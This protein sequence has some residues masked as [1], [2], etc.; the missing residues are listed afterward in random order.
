DQRDGVRI[1]DGPKRVRTYLGGELIADTTRPKLVWEVPYYPA[2][3]FPREDVRTELLTPNGQTRH[4]TS[5]GE[6]QNFRVKG[7]H[8]EAEDLAWSYQTPRQENVK[9]AGLVAFFNEKV[10]L[11][12]DGERQER[13]KTHFS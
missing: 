1:E 12:V 6:A 4:S 3:Y 7:G 10:D 9:I 11:I 13:P 5:R 8:R 2:Y